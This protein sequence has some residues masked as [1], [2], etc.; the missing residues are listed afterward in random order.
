VAFN[1]TDKLLI[2]YWR[3]KL[4]YNGTIP[5]LFVDSKKA[6]DAVRRKVAC[7]I[8]IKFSTL[9]KLLG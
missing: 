5:E 4:E 6:Y 8:L 3:E 2:R 9:T 7:N 1:I